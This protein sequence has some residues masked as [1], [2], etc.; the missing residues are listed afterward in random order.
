VGIAG[1]EAGVRGGF[2]GG[3]VWRWANIS[4]GGAVRLLVDVSFFNEGRVIMA[5]PA[6]CVSRLYLTLY[7]VW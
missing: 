7:L 1:F 3:S 5:M 6:E 2:A 4:T